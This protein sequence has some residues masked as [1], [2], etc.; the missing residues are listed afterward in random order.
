M[1][2]HDESETPSLI[3][4]YVIFLLYSFTEFLL[5]KYLVNHITWIHNIFIMEYHSL[6]GGNKVINNPLI[7]DW[8]LAIVLIVAF[9]IPAVIVTL[10]SSVI[11]AICERILI[12]AIFRIG[13]P[14]VRNEIKVAIPLLGRRTTIRRHRNVQAYS[15]TDIYA[16][17]LVA[18][19]NLYSINPNEFA[20][21]WLL[22]SQLNLPEKQIKLAVL[23]WLE[24]KM[25][26]TRSGGEFGLE[27]SAVRR[28]IFH[29]PRVRINVNGRNFIEDGREHFK[30][31]DTQI[32]H[33]AVAI[34]SMRFSNNMI[35]VKGGHHYY[36][37]NQGIQG[38]N[39]ESQQING[40]ANKILKGT[41]VQLGERAQRT[42]NVFTVARIKL[43]RTD[44]AD[45]ALLG[46]IYNVSAGI[47]PRALDNFVTESIDVSAPKLSDEPLF[48]DVF[49]IA[50]DNVEIIGGWNKQLEYWP[51]SQEPL[52]ASFYFRAKAVG[53]CSLVVDFSFEQ[54]WVQSI[55][56]EFE[57]M[58]AS[59]GVKIPARLS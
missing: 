2:S 49:V 32:N 22:A 10:V 12:G 59:V 52:L 35:T 4:I 29:Y 39:I 7:V 33:I 14:N 44:E 54:R 20:P 11:Y 15:Q 45:V 41:N 13:W 57:C 40:A 56:F 46:E 53:H 24:N 17:T 30:N 48:F 55:P 23:Y 34:R 36:I 9:V 31:G 18:L 38:I 42:R 51:E 8:R 25:V 19:Y 3:L 43:F 21:I 37:Q 5:W 6:L 26:S 58:E 1:P 16:S 28:N 50:N 47:S 27:V